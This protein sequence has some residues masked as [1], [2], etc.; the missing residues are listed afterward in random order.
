V[1]Y[2]LELVVK[3]KEGRRL[4]AKTNELRLKKKKARKSRGLCTRVKARAGNE[5]VKPRGTFDFATVGKGKGGKRGRNQKVVKAVVQT[6]SIPSKTTGF[7]GSRSVEWGKWEEP[8]EKAQ[9][10]RPH[11]ADRRPKSY[12]SLKTATPKKKLTKRYQIWR[13]V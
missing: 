10:S 11:V 2:F 12:H 4:D 8:W 1:A 7:G 3:E 5:M 6:T 13:K 9:E